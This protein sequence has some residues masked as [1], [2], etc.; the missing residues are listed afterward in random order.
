[1]I[2][3]VEHACCRFVT[4][5]V[6]FAVPLVEAIPVLH[7]HYVF[8]N[9]PPRFEDF[10]KANDF[11]RRRPTLFAGLLITLRRAMTRAFRRR[12]DQVN[13]ADLF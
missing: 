2:L 8:N 9:D 11:E 4:H 6:E 13:P 12:E 5:V 10:C 3:S 7:L 1:M